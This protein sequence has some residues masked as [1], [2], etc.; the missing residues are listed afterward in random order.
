MTKNYYYRALS[1]KVLVV[2]IVNQYDTGYEDWAAYIDAVEGQSHK[3]EFMDVA[4]YGS[5][6]DQR[7]AAIIFPAL[8]E[9]YQWRD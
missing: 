3:N 7:I 8:A 5:K 4:R 6:I 1:T 9:K 2:A